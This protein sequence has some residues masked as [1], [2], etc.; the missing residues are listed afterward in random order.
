VGTALL[1]NLDGVRAKGL[2]LQASG[3]F[4]QHHSFFA[5]YT[6]Q[7]SRDRATDALVPGLPSHLANFGV[8]FV[9]RER[10]DATAAVSARGSRP[11][12][13]GDP[14]PP[15]GGYAIVNLNVRVKRIYK[16][17]EGDLALQNLFDEA[18]F[19]PSLLGGVPGD[20]PRAGRRVLLHATLRF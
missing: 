17:L 14:R 6:Y 2:E 1:R 9:Y 10:V 19:D 3:G 12:L 8:T 15:V 4:G 13:P 20:Y 18:Y 16:T 5:N 7:R 11:R